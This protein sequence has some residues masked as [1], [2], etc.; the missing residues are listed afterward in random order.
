VICEFAQCGQTGLLGE[1]GA[2]LGQH[3][4]AFA[5]DLP[6]GSRWGSTK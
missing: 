6:A 1:G 5:D 3:G 2:G 4:E